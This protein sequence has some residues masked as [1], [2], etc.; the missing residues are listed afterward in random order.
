LP[1]LSPGEQAIAVEAWH[2][3][4][5]LEDDA[6]RQH[7]HW[8]HNRT[9]NPQ[10]K[11]PGSFSRQGFFEH[12][13]TCYQEVYPEAANRH[14]SI[15]LFSAVAKEKL[16]VVS[17]SGASLEHN[18]GPTYCSKRHYWKQVAELSYKKYR[19]KMHVA[20][21]SGYAT[22]YKYITDST[23]RKPRSELDAEVWLSKDHPRGVVLKRLLEAGARQANAFAGRTG[24]RG[25][26]SS[27]EGDV[28]K[29][30]RAG[31]V[32]ALVAGEKFQ[33][34][35]QV[36]DHAFALAQNC[37]TRLAEFCT[38][39]G[40]DKLADLIKSAVSIV[41]APTTLA[42]KC[43]SR[44]DLLRKAA[45]EG[46]CTCGGVWAPGAHKV[47]AH[48]GEDVIKFCQDVCRALEIGARR[49]TNMAIIG[50]PGCGKSMVFEPFDDIFHVMGK[51]DSKST[52]P[53]SGIIDAHTLVWQEYYHK[54]KIVLFEDL[55]A[56]LAGERLEIR[57][58]HR[59]NHSHRNTA[60]MFYSSNSLLAVRRDD[61][62]Q[63]QR[64]NT[65]MCER[66][67]IRRWN[68]PIPFNCRQTDFPRCGRCCA[69]FLLLNR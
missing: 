43:S 64:L 1:A 19:V 10:D 46:T 50:E 32:Y 37:D 39:V 38:S 15:L 3:L 56:V 48:Q 52:F 16:G 57:V 27:A 8:V 67:I 21:H 28:T 35:L 69:N 34:I 45:A 23:S 11:Q 36:Q 17:A 30:F 13:C 60:P 55:L 66:F 53:M 33:S 51:P 63:M 62:E 41:E 5:L 47:L 18:H 26:S 29:R 22:M 49:G 31:D 9:N 44:M 68:V 42:L 54:D 2:E 12:L 20:V 24:K 14:G 40:E 25:A 6:R 61:P 65:A 58:P 4:V 59:K 7:M